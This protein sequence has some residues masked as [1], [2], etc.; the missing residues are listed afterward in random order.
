[1]EEEQIYR[2]S[3]H[4]LPFE[5]AACNTPNAMTA[6]KNRHFAA[7]NWLRII[8]PYNLKKSEIVYEKVKKKHSR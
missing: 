6:Y 1:L 2:T 7:R 5:T 8:V 3:A 4:R